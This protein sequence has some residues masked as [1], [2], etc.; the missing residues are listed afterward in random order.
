MMKAMFFNTIFD[1]PL[2]EKP[3]IERKIKIKINKIWRKILSDFNYIDNI[4]D[5]NEI[6]DKMA[7][8]FSSKKFCTKLG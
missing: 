1:K 3:N 5:K 4:I 8:L 7:C 6:K 2:L